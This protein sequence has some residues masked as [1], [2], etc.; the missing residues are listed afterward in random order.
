MENLTEQ[1]LENAILR[2]GK[3]A[4]ERALVL[5]TRPK[6]IVYIPCDITDDKAREMLRELNDSNELW[7]YPAG[8]YNNIC[9]CEDGPHGSSC[10]NV[11]PLKFPNKPCIPTQ[12]A[13]FD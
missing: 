13:V 5:F 9:E 6:N 4:D 10:S 7:S 2:I 3:W 1:T 8:K 11:N 12:V